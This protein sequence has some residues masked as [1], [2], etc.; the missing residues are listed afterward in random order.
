MENTLAYYDTSTIMAS[1]FLLERMDDNSFITMD[2]KKSST[3]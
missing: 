3:F 2:K 1:G